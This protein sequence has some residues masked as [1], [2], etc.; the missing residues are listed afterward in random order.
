M[1]WELID[2]YIGEPLKRTR[3]LSNVHFHL[4]LMIWLRLGLR[5]FSP[6][7]RPVSQHPVSSRRARSGTHILLNQPVFKFQLRYV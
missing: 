4:V 2:T 5:T 7:R 3:I 1:K 6:G